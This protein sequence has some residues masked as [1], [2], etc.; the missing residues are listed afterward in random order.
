MRR[1]KKRGRLSLL[2]LMDPE[3]AGT[4]LEFDSKV[5]P[6]CIFKA[7]GCPDGRAGGMSG[8]I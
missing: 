8:L 6:M 2:G 7:Q 5:S 3:R 4:Q 1:Q